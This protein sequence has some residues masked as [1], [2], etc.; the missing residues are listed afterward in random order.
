[1]LHRFNLSEGDMKD[2]LFCTWDFNLRNLYSALEKI[3]NILKFR[4]KV[5]NYNPFLF[6]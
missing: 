5:Q 2:L 6:I 3:G 4:E 1:M